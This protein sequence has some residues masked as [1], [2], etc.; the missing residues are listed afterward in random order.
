MKPIC[1]IC[2]LMYCALVLS[3]SKSNNQRRHTRQPITNQDQIMFSFQYLYCKN[4]EMFW[5]RKFRQTYCLFWE[6]MVAMWDWMEEGWDFHCTETPNNPAMSLTRK[7]KVD[8]HPNS[9]L[10]LWGQ[11]IKRG[12]NSPNFYRVSQKKLSLVENSRGKYNS[13]GWEIQ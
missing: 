6:L 3:L 13:C 10:F 12:G 8:I 11:A 9:I 2:G 7:E 5:P 1:G 4:L